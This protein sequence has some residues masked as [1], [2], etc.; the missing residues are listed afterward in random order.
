MTIDATPLWYWMNERH[1]IYIRRFIDHAP[2]LWTPDPILQQ[3]RFCNVFREL[4]TVTI[5]LREHIR[6]PLKDHPLLWF[7][8]ALARNINWP[9]T[10]AELIHRGKETGFPDDF[11]YGQVEAVMSQRVARGKKVFG[12]AYVITNGG[13]SIPKE[14]YVCRYVAEPLWAGRRNVQQFLGNQPQKSLEG[15]WEVLRGYEGFGP[16][17]AYEV[18]T[19]WRHTRYLRTAPDIT[20]WAN[21]GP[22]AK[23]GLNRL[24]GLPAGD[25]ITARA[26]LTLMRELLEQANT[27]RA[28]LHVPLPLEMRDIEHSLCETDKYLRAKTGE[29][30]PKQQFRP[31]TVYR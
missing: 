27:G 26:A 28:H 9:D 31:G 10:L 2:P 29:G 11:R 17:I 4:D 18:V 7:W 14:E 24:L 23:R 6:E 3:Y 15:T 21:A 1:A 5:W 16:F 19:D 25:P 12:S 13:R 20:T 8:L 30:R 22:G